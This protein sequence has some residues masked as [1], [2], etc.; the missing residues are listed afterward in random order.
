MRKTPPHPVPC[1]IKMPQKCT[2][3]IKVLFN[4]Y[5]INCSKKSLKK[6]F[7]FIPGVSKKYPLLA[8]NRNKTIRY[9]YSPSRQ[10]SLS[11]F[12]LD[13]HIQTIFFY[14]CCTMLNFCFAFLSLYVTSI[15]LYSILIFRIY[16]SIILPHSAHGGT[17]RT[18]T[19]GEV[20]PIFLG[21]NIAKSDI[22]RP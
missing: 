14:A 12:N 13:S 11:V 21:Q 9:Y 16:S 20:I 3:S 5:I 22:L 4:V 8:G 18:C 15:P 7:I 1:R 17:L 2:L 10:V 6:I 19:Y